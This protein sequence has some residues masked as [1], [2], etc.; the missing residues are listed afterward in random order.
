MRWLL[1]GQPQAVEGPHEREGQHPQ[2]PWWQVM[3]LTGVDYFSTLGY[4]P[5]IAALAAGAL[6][7]IATLVLVLVTL[8]GALPMYRWVAGESPHGDGSISMLERLLSWWQ[9]KLFVLCLIGFVATGFVIT[10]TLS[11]A[12]AAAHLAENPFTGFLHGDEIAVTLA[13]VALLGLVFLKGFGEAIGVAVV[14]VLSYLLLNLVVITV[15]LAQVAQQPQ[16]LADWRQAL[17]QAHGSPLAMAGAALLVFPKLALGLSGFETGVV[18][19]PLVRGEAE[20][21]PQHP[22][23]RIRN[24]RKLLTA[25]AA[26]M[27]VLLISSSLVTT[28]LIPAAEF[29]EGG[30]A[31]GRALAYLAHS[32]LGDGFGTLYDLSTILILW[33][34]G[35]SALAGLLNIVPRYL[36]RYGMAP[37]WAAVTR[38]LVLIFTAVCFAVTLIFRASVEAQAGAYATG[39]LAV[40]T[41]AVI[42]VALSA[43]R[44][45]RRLAVVGFGV[46]AVIFLY[47]TAITIVERP[48]GLR[49]ALLFIV[50]IVVTSVISR[51]WRA[52]EL[53]ATGVELDATARRFVEDACRGET[54]RLIAHDTDRRDPG[55]YAHKVREQR[56]CNHMP[57]DSPPLFLEVDVRDPSE[58]ASVLH[59]RGDEV[60][61]YRVLRG[62][63]T[64]VANAIAALLLHLRDLTGTIP[65]AYF[66]W[67]ESGPLGQALRYVLFGEGDIAPVT[68]EVLRKAEPDPE[69]RPI[70]HAA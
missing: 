12:D 53:R 59:V 56:C 42:A 63:A 66:S 28:L 27:S 26:I 45:R 3:C 1:W 58:F 9:G 33:F 41:S 51:L 20:D 24:A 50:A 68:H 18:V 35:A 22:R 5:G 11:A 47:T 17:I 19:M 65:H 4:Q 16:L 48:E 13:L 7:P 21:D 43:R 70:V 67:S 32:Y 29:E 57:S 15:G 2:H 30:K 6:S 36:P 8:F 46:I 34:A 61:G 31:S 39:V 38:P 54:L 49:I 60:G 64:S 40:M 52:T 37:E 62:E 69:R 25:A 10:I 44:Q 23:G 14:L 55:E